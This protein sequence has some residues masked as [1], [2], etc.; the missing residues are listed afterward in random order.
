MKKYFEVSFTKNDVCCAN[1]AH[2][3]TTE[4]VYAYYNA[5]QNVVVFGVEPARDADIAEARRK[6]MPI[7]E[8]EHAAETATTESINNEEAL[9]MNGKKMATSVLL[10]N[11]NK[12]Y[13]AVKAIE[14]KW[15]AFNAGA[16]A[17]KAFG[18]KPAKVSA[19]K[20]VNPYRI[21]FTREGNILTLTQTSYPVTIHLTEMGADLFDN[22]AY[23]PTADV[24][25][26]LRTM[27][28]SFA[29]ILSVTRDNAVHAAA[30]ATV[31]DFHADVI[32][33]NRETA[34]RALR[35]LSD[36]FAV[37]FNGNK[38]AKH[39]IRVDANELDYIVP[40]MRGATGKICTF[41]TFS[42]RVMRLLKGLL[43]GRRLEA[44]DFKKKSANTN[45]KKESAAA[46]AKRL[47][48]N[49]KELQKELE[50]ARADA[51]S[52]S[53]YKDT[54]CKLRALCADHAGDLNSV[55]FEICTLLGLS[56]D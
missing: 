22:G 12:H 6:G 43:S 44:I 32:A 8:V 49:N 21:T 54:V 53:A 11:A 23:T 35:E 38:Q 40:E 39:A 19:E 34:A 55:E 27:Y 52:L 26:A 4:D 20:T 17:A 41:D 2:A 45:E 37:R 42:A 9:I 56:W 1:I 47:E 5:K 31:L 25:Q 10:E 14:G 30:D 28:D 36:L 7:V 48:A 18:D 13:N 24:V 51:L 3:E 15:D 46:K 29:V 16:S 50:T 33:R